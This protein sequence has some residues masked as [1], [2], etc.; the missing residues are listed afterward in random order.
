MDG[1]R[2]NVRDVRRRNRSVLLSK[3]Y[4]D[5]TLSRQDLSERTGLSA[6]SVSNLVAELIDEG[7][8][9]EAGS[10]ESD[11]GRPR[12]LL[13][14]APDFAH[15]V[16][17][18][19][20]ETR[21]QVELFDL[22]MTALAKAEF[23]MD[24]GRP[25]P[26]IVVGHILAG[27]RQVAE[28]APLRSPDIL[29]VGIGVNGVVEQG[30][31]AVV[32]A[33]QLGWDGHAARADGAGRHR[34]AAVPGQRRQGAGPGRDVVRRR[35]GRRHAVIAL[36]GSGVGAAVVTD[37]TQLPRRDQQRRRVGPHH[38]DVRRPAV[39]LRC[40]R[41]P[42]GLRRGRRGAGPVP[43]ANGGVPAPGRTRSL[44]CAR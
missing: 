16:G 34:P 18:D 27:L 12:I 5:G 19:V 43:I 17:I 1:K 33:Q 37:G 28:E 7:V 22:S 4:F 3:L 39:P 36:V 40:T 11:G 35:T 23:P 20:G 14:V 44:P 24:P 42:G 38:P 10:E 30:S 31:E 26:E 2:T 41:L 32:H 13:R 21:V 15:V 25:E 29:G 8:V 6:A 9:E